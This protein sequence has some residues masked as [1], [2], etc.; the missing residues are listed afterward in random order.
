MTLEE[1]KKVKIE[2]TGTL[3]DGTVFDSSEKHGQPL[4]FEIGKKQVIPG[5]EEA[6]KE[7]AVGEEKEITITPAD[8][9]G[10]INDQLMQKV[11]R[12]KLPKEQEPKEGMMLMMKT[13]D[14]KQFPAKIAK[15]DETEI[16][17]NLNHPLAGKTLKFKIKL[18]ETS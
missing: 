4:E 11:P 1:G 17:L 10:E 18:I 2:Y 8:G 3:E 16:T 9:Y 5:F 7:L 12:D 6:V 14:G 13:P 15:V